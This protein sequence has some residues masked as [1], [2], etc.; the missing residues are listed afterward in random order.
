MNDFVFGVICAVAVMAVFGM[1]YIEY[2]TEQANS[3]FCIKMGGTKYN[4]GA[5]IAGQATCMM[6]NKDGSY[7]L[8]V[9]K[10]VN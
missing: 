1:L 6:T 9:W 10:Y 5:D 3:N 7:T 8:K 4:V 2:S